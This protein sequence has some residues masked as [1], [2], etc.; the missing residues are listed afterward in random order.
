MPGEPITPAERATG[1][2]SGYLAGAAELS[3][4]DAS[5]LALRMAGM[6]ADE[7]LVPE[8]GVDRL[9]RRWAAEAASS[10][11]LDEGTAVGLAWLQHTGMPRTAPQPGELA[12]WPVLLPPVAILTYDSPRNLLSASFHLAGLTH[13]APESQ[14]GAVA[15]NVALARLLQGFRDIVPDVIEA[16]R[17]NEAPPA[18]LEPTRRLPLLNRGDIVTLAR[19][20]SPAATTTI[21]A[22]WLAHHEPKADRGMGWLAEVPELRPALPAAGALFGARGGP[23]P[24]SESRVARGGPSGDIRALAVRLARIPTT[25]GTS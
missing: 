2:L 10:P 14:W 8:P 6:L 3:G 12:T 16:L 18:L 17:N 24:L 11:L 4:P 23:V 20:G 9:A 25:S 21:A 15:V 1:L 7:L 5:A 13:P 19:S 22:L